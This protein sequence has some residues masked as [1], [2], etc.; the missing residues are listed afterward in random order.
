MIVVDSLLI[1]GLRFVFDK[2]AQ[3]VD[4]ELSDP[5]RLREELLA[6]QMRFELGEIDEAEL[7]RIETDVMAR[8]RELTGEG[9]ARGPL[10]FGRGGVGGVDVEMGG[11]EPGGS[12][13]R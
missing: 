8:L 3:A 1:G 13:S 10:T 4:A 7:G 9:A 11:D 2:V 6:A 5:D 12:S